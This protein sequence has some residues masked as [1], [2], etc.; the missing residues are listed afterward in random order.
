MGWTMPVQSAS[1]RGV[2]FDVLSVADNFER[3]VVEHSY[4]YIDGADL[5]D[6]GM[7]VRTVQM[8]AVF[9]GEG[10]YTQLK[11]F[12]SAIYE[13][14]EGTNVLVHPILGRMLNMLLVSA[15]VRHEAD[16]VNYALL[17]LTFKETTPVSPSF[18]GKSGLLGEIDRL[19]NL[20]EDFADRYQAFYASVMETA[21]FAYNAKAR[22]LNA[23]ALM[24]STNEQVRAIFNL[25]KAKFGLSMLANL[26]PLAQKEQAISAIAQLDKMIKIG[27]DK[28]AKRA[29]LTVRSGFDEVLREVGELVVIPQNLATGKSEKVPTA[30]AIAQQIK[31]Q[32]VGNE[33]SFASRQNEATPVGSSAMT[34][35]RWVKAES[36][37]LHCAM[38]LICTA[39]L[40]R[41][42]TE[43][44]EEQAESLL[45]SEIEY[46]AYQLRLSVVAS[47]N[48]VRELQR[49]DMAL[50]QPA[51]PNT[52]VYQDAYQVIEGLRQLAHEINQVAML[53]I[54]RKPPLVVKECEMSGTLQQI[55]HA[56]YGDYRRADELRRLNPD[57]YP[58]LV[59][60]KGT[61]LN[62]Y[63]K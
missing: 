42:G 28:T 4:P 35:R 7:N 22:I 49:V 46:I 61:F 6:M 21:A 24:T 57:L 32:A 11:A 40:I 63:T 47:L 30:T 26:S 20:V 39:H 50:A 8:Q 18:E 58:R 17:D 2:R 51:T 52:A 3:A 37:P 43:I 48:L 38:R 62:A 29:N 5:E 23:V 9:F 56:F 44:I 36:L 14:R 10:Y 34:S 33:G 55:A 41:I 13:H 16:Y 25:D 27:L 15:T 60:Q 1:Y 53:A 31:G 12:L 19:L 59:V 54:N 45:P